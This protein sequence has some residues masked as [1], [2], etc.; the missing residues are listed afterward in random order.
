[1]RQIP[2]KTLRAR[3][4]EELKKLPFEIT[5]Y[6]HVLA[7]VNEKGLNLREAKAEKIATEMVKGLNNTENQTQKDI[8]GLNNTAEAF[9]NPQP[10]GKK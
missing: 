6:G 3:L 10:K 4:T 9:F 5:S 2:L 1:M 8:K 7:V